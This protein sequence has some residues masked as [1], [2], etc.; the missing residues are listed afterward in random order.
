MQ[1]KWDDKNEIQYMR[2]PNLNLKFS[3]IDKERMWNL[4]VSKKF[5]KGEKSYG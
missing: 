2:F 4:I 1:I 3:T 5:M